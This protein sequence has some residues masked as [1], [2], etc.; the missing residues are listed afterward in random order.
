[1]KFFNPTSLLASAICMATL[2][3]GDIAV[4]A[5]SNGD[6]SPSS[7]RGQFEARRKMIMDGN[8]LRA[9][10]HNFGWGGRL[11]ADSPDEVPYEYP[12]NTNREYI[13]LV[14]MFIGAEVDNQNPSGLPDDQIP[15]VLTPSGR[16]SPDGTTWDM[17][18][19]PG[20]AASGIDEFARS[21]D[22][23]TWPD[24]WPNRA[25]DG[26]WAG[27]WSGYFGRNQFNADQEFYY[28]ASGN[29][30]TRFSNP[31]NPDGSGVY[32]PDDTDPSRG[33]LGIIMDTRIMSWSQTLIS[34]THF[35]IFEINNDSSY[36][37]DK[38][39]FS[40]W[41]ATL[42]GGD[43]APEDRIIFD[44]QQAVSYLESTARTNAPPTF[45]G[46]N[47]GMAGI[48]FLETPGNSIDGIDNDADSDTFFPEGGRF[49][50]QN[51]DLLHPL[52]EAGGGFFEN[53]QVIL[54]EVIPQFQPS[55]FEPRF[56]SPGDRIVAITDNNDR[57]IKEYPEGGGTIITQ[58]REI[59]LPPGGMEVRED[60]TVATP[61]SGGPQERLHTTLRD[62]DLDGLIDENQP[63]HLEAQILVG[64][65]FQ[66]LP[67]RYIN[68]LWEGYEVGDTLQRGMIVPNSWIR[69]RMATDDNFRRDIDDYQDALRRVHVENGYRSEG[70]FDDYFR[71]YHTQ[72]PMIDE[73]RSDYFDNNM[74][75]DFQDDVGLDGSDFTG[76]PGEGDGFPTSGAGTPFPGEPNID[77]TSVAE[78]DMIGIQAVGF[79]PVGAL[80][81]GVN[82]ARD[83]Q[84]W[85]N[86]QT[87]GTFEQYQEGVNVGDDILV[88][89]SYFPLNRG[90]TERFSVAV[91]VAQTNGPSLEDDR[92]RV[93]QNLEEAFN[94][95]E[96]D[97][98]FAT[99][100][101]APQLKAVPGDGQVTL[102][103][104]DVAEDHFDRF[105]DRLPQ[106]G[107]DQARNFQGYKVYRSTDPGLND[108]RNIT[109]SRGNRTFREPLAIFDLDN[110][111]SGLHPID[112]NGIR[113]NLGD[114]S[115]IQRKFVDTNVNNGRTYYY[116]VTSYTW[117]S[118]P[119]EISPSESPI[120]VSVLPDGTVS[121]GPN[122]QVV[123]PAASQAGKV[124]PEHPQ[125]QLA[126]GT[127]SGIAEIELV[128]PDS[129]RIGNIYEIS[130]RDTLIDGGEEP[131]TL[132]TESFTL[133]NA[134]DQDTLIARSQNLNA[135]DNPVRQG[136]RPIMR[137]EQDELAFNPDLSGFQSERE[138]VEF[139]GISFQLRGA[140]QAA[141]Y[142]LV[143]DEVGY[144]ESV[145]TTLLNRNMPARE[146]NFRAY[147]TSLTDEDGNPTEVKFAFD[148]L[149]SNENPD[150][151]V[152][153][154]NFALPGE[155]S[156]GR[157]LS[158][159]GVAETRRDRVLIIEDVRGEPD[160]FTWLLFMNPRTERDEETN[161]DVVSSVNP[162]AGDT[163]QIRT[164]KPFTENDLFRFQMEDIHTGLVDD[165]KVAEE[166]DNIRV[167]PNPYVVSNP[168]E[169]QGTSSQ[170]DQRR[171]LH[172]THLPKPSTLR[173]FTVS[174]RLVDEINISDG[175]THNG[176]FVWNL[177]TRDELELSY[178]VY[179]YHVEVPGIGET[180]GKFAVIK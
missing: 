116:A 177:L 67:V 64:N 145:D 174:G 20:Y 2:F 152:V 153:D 28:R 45:E 114:N 62:E 161:R 141:D 85:N 60:T 10:Y 144:G 19:I 150:A 68:Y 55:D 50:P 83:T 96:A 58:G 104:D 136:F 39:A 92:R 100:P 146:T 179:L 110:E 107:R 8:N 89:S 118:V 54:N 109:D 99:A 117:G 84:F 133:V 169:P 137:N 112:V 102:Y 34:D 51:P 115:G 120:R 130:F 162:Q 165:E 88:T 139:H 53:R 134:T 6:H 37:Y 95:Y 159:I 125:A 155:F 21:D 77:E 69:E 56:I 12:I 128:D 38:M 1:M 158:P 172:F 14:S 87:P 157:R 16:Q 26:G 126:R 154:N 72:A 52:T 138:D 108:I 168:F 33:G 18:P 98:Q 48:Q 173:I 43:G 121:T 86:F 94:A 175:N 156:A 143:F 164:T 132:R 142:K 9:T 124:E 41:L 78:S 82:F 11:D 147:N 49:N 17:N 71:N 46:G 151:N 90:E 131:D 73:S 4:F 122:V 31:S 35:K 66:E 15:I 47:I 27:D 65:Q 29:Q 123:R 148:Q 119:H 70:A 61:L 166:L 30:Y 163:L 160:V 170:P 113:F 149:H 111:H 13:A 80:G 5:Q 180:T 36:D 93:N 7:E 24:F 40:L 140:P 101:P 106:R 79:S 3:L 76:S 135:E 178:G 63:N 97:Y 105:L 127:T 129:V 75:W 171:E 74:A 42:V 25:E 176:T 44:E 57:V 22:P 81:D 103:W 23:N 59:E 91:T 32:Q 167:V